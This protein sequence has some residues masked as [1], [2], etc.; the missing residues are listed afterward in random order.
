MQTKIKNKLRKLIVLSERGSTEHERKAAN[1]LLNVLLKKY[2]I[3]I[4]DLENEEILKFKFYFV[5]KYEKRLLFQVIFKVLN[6]DKLSYTQKRKNIFI[7]VS[8]KQY[9]KIEYLFQIYKRELK[10]ELNTTYEAF[11]II[12]EIFQEKQ[13]KETAFIKDIKKIDKILK[14]TDR[15]TATTILDALP[16]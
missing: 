13:N 12:N 6:T 15:M 7:D 8:R 1:T 3:T 5:S 16:K 14:F 11:V 10:K 4:D 2:N 9:C